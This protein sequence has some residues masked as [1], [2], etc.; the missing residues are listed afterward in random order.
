MSDKQTSYQVLQANPIAPLVSGPFEQ[1]FLLCADP[2]VDEDALPL[3]ADHPTMLALLGKTALDGCDWLIYEWER[4]GQRLSDKL[5][6]GPLAQL[7]ALRLALRL[8]D[9]ICH[10]R[11][12]GLAIGPIKSAMVWLGADLAGARLAAVLPRNIAEGD[13][14]A[15][16]GGLIYEMLTGIPP[17]RS[18]EGDWLLPSL[19][20]PEVGAQLESIILSAIDPPGEHGFADP[21]A[22]RLALSEYLAELEALMGIGEELGA[23]GKLLRR[24]NDSNDFPAL[25]RAIGAIN[26]VDDS[27]KERLQSLSG[28]ILR[29]VSLTN[30]VLRM[31]NSASYS[32]FGGVSTV[33]RAVMLLGFVTIKAL[34][35]SLVLI[36][37]LKNREQAVDLCNEVARAFL[38]SLISRKVAERLHFRDV[39]EARIGGMLHQLGR[40]LA[41]YYFPAEAQLVQLDVNHGVA[42]HSAAHKH[43]GAS[44]D[45]MGLAVGKS[46]HLPERLLASMS[47]QETHPR[48]PKTESDSLRLFAHTGQTLTD[49]VLH[50]R[51]DERQQAIS[52][53][54]QRYSPALHLS[55]R[56]IRLLLDEA[57]RECITQAPVFG[58]EAQAE[59]IFAIMRAACGLP[60]VASTQK[61]Q[62][63]GTSGALA[64]KPSAAKTE[65]SLAGDKPLVKLAANDRPEVIEILASCVQEVTETLIGEFQLN[66]LLRM[67]VETIYRGLGAQRTLLASRSQQR[68]AIVGR[69]GFGDDLAAFMH[70]FSM[71]LEESSD[72]IRIALAYHTDVLIQDWHEPERRER[73]PSWLRKLG[74]GRSILLLPLVKDKNIVGLIYADHKDPGGLSIGPREL[75]LLKTLRNQALLAVIQKTAGH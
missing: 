3:D 57:M 6:D 74:P 48:A 50:P 45:E 66:E 32:Q 39:E 62:S 67:I 33:S 4:A 47:A 15:Q 35:M 22:L 34:A 24:M 51:A 43:L 68:Q 31:A 70:G 54:C 56:E 36:E 58:V 60:P 2:G 63:G 8:L 52:Q 72:V 17:V 21:L 55:E 14:V 71:P 53:A 25:S 40:L 11:L 9:G 1:T 38:A 12:T 75:S 20:N 49:A 46:W 18:P 28:V 64:R 16:V 26:R 10:T 19:I 27:D 73:M 7:D 61:P 13:V 65:P 5:E 44:F 30:K 37:Q 29:D 42:E 41:H 69:L 59:G 23:A